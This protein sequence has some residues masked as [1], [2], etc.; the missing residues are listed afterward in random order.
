MAKKKAGFADLPKE[1]ADIVNKIVDEKPIERIRPT[2][3][4]QIEKPRPVKEPVILDTIIPEAYEIEED[5]YDTPAFIVKRKEK[6]DGIWDVATEDP[7]EFFDSSLAYEITGYRPI[8]ETEGL[9]FNPEWFMEARINKLKTGHYYSE[10]RKGSKGYDDFWYE[11]YNRLNNGMTVNGYTITGDNYYFINYYRL[12]DLSQTHKAGSG[13]L[14]TFPDFLVKQYEYFHYIELCRYARKNAVGLKSRGVG[15]SEIGA[16]L[17]ANTYI[18]KRETRCVIAAQQAGYLERTLDKCW[19]QLNY[20]NEHTDDG[21]YKPLGLNQP[22]LKKSYV[23]TSGDKVKKGWLSEIEGINADKPNKIRGD[24]TDLL[25]Y[26]ESGSWPNWKKAFIQGDALVFSNGYRFGI[27]LGWGT[28]GDAGPALAGIADAFYNWEAYDILPYKHNYTKTGEQ[29]VTAY[30]IPSYTILQSIKDK[31]GWTDPVKGKEMYDKERTKKIGD[32]EAYILYCAEYCYTPDEAL[33]L[34]GSNNF[35]RI[36]LVDQLSEIKQFKRGP[37]IQRGLLEYD[38]RGR[39]H[40]EENIAGFKF[41]ESR[42]AKLKIIE[43][44]KRDTDGKAFRNL[45]VAG[46][47]S[48][49][50]GQNDT[51]TETKDPSDF[52]IVIKRRAFGLNPPAY[53]A[54][55]KDRPNDIREAYKI[56]LR[57]LEYYN[58]QAV[59]ENSKISLRQYFQ[60]RN[61]ANK[62]LMRRPRATQTDSQSGN[63]KQFGAPTTEVV[64]RHQLELVAQY[65][66]D[67]C[68]EIWF[69][70]IIEELIHYSY[71]NKRKFDIVAA[72]G[73]CELGDEE[74][75]GFVPKPIDQISSEWRDIVWYTDKDGYKRQG[76]KPVDVYTP[77]NN[78]HK[79]NQGYDYNYSGYRDSY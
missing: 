1:I 65:I 54:I 3:S 70:E 41:L 56:A 31:R 64:I 4:I 44:P 22:L 69:E 49:D 25:L 13:R 43:H 47:D 66:E 17:A 60:E 18:R 77:P 58:C 10:E 61:K 35:N 9:D 19:T 21:F 79:I 16:C 78:L 6:K 24:R 59:L 72:M 2:S 7:I 68:S 37:Q 51:S 50:H 32:P 34:E 39:E 67:Y 48:I 30:F 20:C 63:S 12:K 55:Y 23:E 74:L 46:I 76:V 57:L 5:I 14:E 52:C 53:V 75:Q 40:R 71:E 38:F 11:E 33:A 42:T 62:Y 73:M 28:G 8:N 36:L 45:Y 29:A 15:F 27:K 26:E